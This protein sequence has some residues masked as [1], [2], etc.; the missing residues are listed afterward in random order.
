MTFHVTNF[1]ISARG[2][3]GAILESVHTHHHLPLLYHHLPKRVA[4]RDSSIK[5]VNCESFVVHTMFFPT[6]GFCHL[7]I[8]APSTGTGATICTESPTQ[9]LDNQNATPTAVAA[10]Y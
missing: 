4:S 10:I 9:P 1:E 5:H 6:V 3:N 8:F 7:A 2:A